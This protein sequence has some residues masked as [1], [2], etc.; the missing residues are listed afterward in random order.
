MIIVL[1][2]VQ[3]KEAISGEL[4]KTLKDTQNLIHLKTKM[5]L[6]DTFRKITQKNQKADSKP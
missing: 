2:Q 6:S 5:N 4:S 3:S 1:K